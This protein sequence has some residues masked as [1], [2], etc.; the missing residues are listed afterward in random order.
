[1][2]TT[3]ILSHS[4]VALLLAP[5]AIEASPD[6]LSGLNPAWATGGNWSLGFAP[7]VGDNALITATGIVD[8]NGAALG[9]LRELQDITFSALNNVTLA[10]DRKSVV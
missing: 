6:T 5:I 4:I 8:V 9:G 1:M 7:G 3:R 10:K 2:R